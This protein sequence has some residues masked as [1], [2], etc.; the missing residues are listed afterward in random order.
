MFQ[1]IQ[2]IAAFDVKDDVLQFEGKAKA[3]R[4]GC[5]AGTRRLSCRNS[6]A[7]SAPFAQTKV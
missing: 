5:Y 4:R 6:G 3:E 7:M 2:Q 1:D